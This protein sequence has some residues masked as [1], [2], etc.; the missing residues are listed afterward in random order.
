MPQFITKLRRDRWRDQV[1]TNGKRLREAEAAR[2]GVNASLWPH[3][4][5][6]LDT[7][8][9]NYTRKRD[10]LLKKLKETA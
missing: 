4:A 3:D 8:I 2:A 6:Y 7:L 5:A 9:D 1:I 10:R